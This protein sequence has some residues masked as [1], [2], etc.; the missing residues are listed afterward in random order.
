MSTILH[1]QRLTP[2]INFGDVNAMLASSVSYVCP[3]RCPGDA[4]SQFELD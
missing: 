2:T 4:V 3:T 1:L